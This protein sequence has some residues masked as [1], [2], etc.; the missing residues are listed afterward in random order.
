MS[1]RTLHPPIFRALISAAALGLSI[2]ALAQTGDNSGPLPRPQPYGDRGTRGP[3][4][5][6]PINYPGRNQRPGD[7]VRYWQNRIFYVNG[8]PCYVP[9]YYGWGFGGFVDQSGMSIGMQMGGIGMGFSQARGAYLDGGQYSAYGNGWV[10]D[11]GVVRRANDQGYTDPPRQ[12]QRTAASSAKGDDDD[13]YLNAKPKAKGA[14]EK[15]PALSE[16]L[17]DIASAFISGN[18][19]LLEKH[20][21]SS[22]TIVL[23]NKGRTR[24]TMTVVNYLEMTR[25]AVKTMK[26]V[27]YTLPNVEP[28]S[29]GATMVYGT[30]VLR[31]EDGATRT[32]N[33]GFV[34]KKTGDKYMI[35]EVGA[36]PAD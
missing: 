28:A 6:P 24:Q 20:V 27:S 3:I 5:N 17:R 1:S 35:T 7:P 12:P 13:Y 8:S 21:A 32:F 18:I 10:F 26:T 31:T 33:V 15:D 19:S 29:N 2:S 34:L 14:T 25:D 36:D 9:M 4:G 11:N 23:Q 16:A 30:H 22:G